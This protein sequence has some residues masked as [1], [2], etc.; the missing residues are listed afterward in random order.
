MQVCRPAYFV[1][2]QVLV[3]H[4][5]NDWWSPGQT[6]QAAGNA[7][8]QVATTAN[9]GSTSRWMMNPIDGRKKLEEQTHRRFLKKTSREELRPTRLNC[10]RAVCT[11]C[12]T[13]AALSPLFRFPRR[14][15]S[16]LRER[17]GKQLHGSSDFGA[18][19]RFHFYCRRG[20]WQRDVGFLA[21]KFRGSCV[22]F[23]NFY[24]VTSDWDWQGKASADEA[25]K[26]RDTGMSKNSPLVLMAD[27]RTLL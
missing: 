20:F 23:N 27:F 18:S 9:G 10:V 7:V 14:R 4:N 21:T 26:S 25:M 16:Y 11:F 6:A 2:V 24:C 22:T 8:E 12:M 3:A 1:Q 15:Q 17:R 13:T 19:H 5:T